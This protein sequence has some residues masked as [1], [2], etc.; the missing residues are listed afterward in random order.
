[1]TQLIVSNQISEVNQQLVISEQVTIEKTL[2]KYLRDISKQ[3][4][5]T[6]YTLNLW[7]L[8]WTIPNIKCDIFNGLKLI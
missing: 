3:V 2:K 4:L 1:M 7:Q 8:L 5:E 6:K